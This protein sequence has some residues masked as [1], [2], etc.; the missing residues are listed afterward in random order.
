MRGNSIM[1]GSVVTTAEYRG[2]WVEV[3]A[4]GSSAGGTVYDGVVYRNREHTGGRVVVI[5]GLQ[6]ATSAACEA[7]YLVD[8]LCERGAA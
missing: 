3:R 4:V 6:S 1:A 5:Y 2:Y 8:H 7:M